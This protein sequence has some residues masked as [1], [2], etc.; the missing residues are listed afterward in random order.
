MS[1]SDIVPDKFYRH[2]NIIN[3]LILLWQIGFFSQFINE[4]MLIH[5][6]PQKIWQYKFQ[7]L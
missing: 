4:A 5:L 6:F 2:K 3:L 7:Y 1:L